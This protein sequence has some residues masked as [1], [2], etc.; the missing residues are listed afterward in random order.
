LREKG[1]KGKGGKE[2]NPP[3]SQLATRV[4][5]KL[6]ESLTSGSAI[7][8]GRPA[9]PLQRNMRGMPRIQPPGE[10][11]SHRQAGVD[12]R[13]SPGN[14]LL[15]GLKRTY[16][17]SPKEAFPLLKDNSLTDRLLPFDFSAFLPLEF[18]AFDLIPGLEKEI[19]GAA[20]VLKI[21]G[22]EKNGV[23]PGKNG[24]IFRLNPPPTAESCLTLSG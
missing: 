12:R 23:G 5:T 3:P 16:S 2:K 15:S 4:L 22:P 17:R 8:L 24:S 11:D 13:C 19:R 14:A 18:K 1:E 7:L 6:Y 21:K 9:R 10:T 20:L